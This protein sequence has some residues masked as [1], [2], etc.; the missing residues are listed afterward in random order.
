ML[1]GG[2]ARMKGSMP[3]RRRTALKRKNT[4]SNQRGRQLWAQENATFRA[5]VCFLLCLIYYAVR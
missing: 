5:L 4:V 2:G 3:N 1:K